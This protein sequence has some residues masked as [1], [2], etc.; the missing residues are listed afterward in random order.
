MSGAPST[1]ANDWA[2]AVFPTPAAPSTN[3]GRRIVM[4]RYAA[5][6]TPSSGRYPTDSSASAS[7]P[8]VLTPPVCRVT[9]DWSAAA[10][11]D[12][13][14]PAGGVRR[15]DVDERVADALLVHLLRVVVV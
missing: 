2:S 14:V 11:V 6:A 1:S 15:L 12:G 7:S 10:F 3:N 8:G 4:A 13:H 5:V 9:A